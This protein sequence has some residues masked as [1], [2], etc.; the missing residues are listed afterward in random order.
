MAQS[1]SIFKW[2]V[3]MLGS[4]KQQC[5]EQFVWF[6]SSLFGMNR[7][8]RRKAEGE[9]ESD[10]NTSNQTSWREG[11]HTISGLC[12]IGYFL[13]FQRFQKGSNRLHF[14]IISASMEGT[15]VKYI[16]ITAAKQT[17]E[18]DERNH[19]REE[20][21]K[22][23]WPRDLRRVPI[24]VRQLSRTTGALGSRIWFLFACKDIPIKRSKVSQ[25]SKRNGGDIN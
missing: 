3:R 22:V 1:N 12:K 7:F 11:L 4:F 10:L 14:I 2:S 17:V 18:L 24:L 8:C 15:S 21:R 19:Y 16:Y 6:A 9:K 13:L 23:N 20:T 25:Y 5:Q